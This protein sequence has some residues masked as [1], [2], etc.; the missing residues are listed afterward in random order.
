[1]S[2]VRI[3]VCAV[4]APLRRVNINNMAWVWGESPL[5]LLGEFWH[6]YI[7]WGAVVSSFI[8]PPLGLGLGLGLSLGHVPSRATQLS[9]RNHFTRKRR[10]GLVASGWLAG[11]GAACGARGTARRERR[12]QDGGGVADLRRG[13]RSRRAAVALLDSVRSFSP[14]ARQHDGRGRLLTRKH[15]GGRGEPI[16]CHWGVTS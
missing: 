8:S 9:L 15:G 12:G 6:S 3:C 1:M 7:I 16:L 14:R 11:A 2:A 10:G 13:P 4:L 5:P